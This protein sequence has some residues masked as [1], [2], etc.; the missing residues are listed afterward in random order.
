[1]ILIRGTTQ[2]QRTLISALCRYGTIQINVIRYRF[3]ITA[4]TP[5]KST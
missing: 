2:I 1:M 4:G 5:L 3:P